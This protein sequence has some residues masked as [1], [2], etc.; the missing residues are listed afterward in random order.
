MTKDQLLQHKDDMENLAGAVCAA[1]LPQLIDWLKEKDDTLR[2]TAFLLLQALSARDARV[3]AFWPVFAGML[4]DENSYQR[5]LGVMLIAANIP[6]DRDGHFR[7]AC[8]DYLRCCGDEKFITSR[9]AIQGLQKIVD[10]TEAYR[11]DIIKALT[12][13]QLAGRKDSQKG[14]LLLDIA[15]VL[16]ALYKRMPDARIE[17]YLRQN[18][19]QGNDKAKKLIQKILAG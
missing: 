8:Q 16:T 19:S 3:Y 1:E 6:W 7:D 2:Y 17:A 14:L 12:A 10:A 15:E 13:I 18:L 11:E 5:S 4:K 9:Q